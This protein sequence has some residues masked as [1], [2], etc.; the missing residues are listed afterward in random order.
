MTAQRKR[1]YPRRLGLARS[2]SDPLSNQAEIDPT[3]A[4]EQGEAE[5]VKE[6]VAE[7][8]VDLDQ[9]GVIN[10]GDNDPEVPR[11]AVDENTEVINIGEPMDPDDPQLGRWMRTPRSSISASR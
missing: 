9:D 5:A 4:G 2:P 10:I 3:R 6:V 11:L 1:P 7:E 8:A